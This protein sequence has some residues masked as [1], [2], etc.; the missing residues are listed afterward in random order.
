M[1]DT[2]EFSGLKMP[3]FTAFGW[4]GEETAIQFALSQ[5]E[6]FIY[7]LHSKISPKIKE[8]LPFRDFSKTDQNVYLSA[9]ADPEND[10][11]ITYNA[12]TSSLEMAIVLS[13][14]DALD[15]TFKQIL[16]QP[17]LAH[18]LITELG[19]EW[20]IHVQQMEYDPEKR[21]SVK[22]QDIFKDNISKFDH[23]TA[24]SVFEKAAY[25]NSEDKWVTPVLLF[26]RFDAEKVAA[27]GLKV[28]D[29]MSEE[30]EK[31]STLLI[32]LTGQ[33]AKKAAKR[34]KKKAATKNAARRK[35]ASAKEI[36][37]E[38]I[39]DGF[40]YEAELKPLH[41][42]KGFVNMTPH[43]WP[44][45]SINSRTETR[46]VTVYYD[47]IYDKGCAVWRMLPNDQARLVLS[48]PVHKWLE[49]NFAPDEFL[50]LT[51]TKIGSNEIQ[52][53]LKSISE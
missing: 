41:I 6:L 12:R 46:P 19:T 5:L 10:I 31:L 23:E 15:K 21:T 28:V 45:F 18:R 37:P 39:E 20:S 3:V 34:A 25:L 30:I 44:F 40:S 49:D 8:I 32:F 4:A 50:Q 42:R 14:K 13:N 29:V 16:K 2:N 27:M 9:Q 52:I 24:V 47:G 7:E 48:P 11:S 38:S 33:V 26:R 43:H 35:K 36:L 22:Y 51:A 1:S 17:V 53:S